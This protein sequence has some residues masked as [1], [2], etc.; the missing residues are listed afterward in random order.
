MAR[1]EEMVNRESWAGGADILTESEW[2]PHLVEPTHSS[3]GHAPAQHLQPYYPHH[4]AEQI[5]PV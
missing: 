3:F 4:H 2:L 5:P 1:P